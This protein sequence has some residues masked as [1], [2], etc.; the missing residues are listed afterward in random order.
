MPFAGPTAGDAR[1]AAHSNA[2][3][4]HAALPS[5]T[6]ASFRYASSLDIVPHAWNLTSLGE[7]R[8]LYVPDIPETTILDSL[9]KL[10]TSVASGG[11]YTQL[12][13]PDPPWTGTIDQSRIKPPQPPLEEIDSFINYLRQAV[14][15]HTQAYDQ[16]L[17]LDT[18]AAMPEAPSAISVS[19]VVAQLITEAGGTLP[20][21]LTVS[22]EPVSRQMLELA[23][24]SVTA[25]SSDTTTKV[26]ALVDAMRRFAAEG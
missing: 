2:R 24:G 20:S 5:S 17:G 4:P 23:I 9:V 19:P 22:S 12:T 7:L 25:R 14:Y 18:T 3:L 1:F 11:D 15:Q 6:P 10:A 8:T 26:E 21:D 16:Y 13:P